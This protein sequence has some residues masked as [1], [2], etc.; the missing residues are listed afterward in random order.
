MIACCTRCNDSELAEKTFSAWEAMR[1][2]RGM[3]GGLLVFEALIAHHVRRK[4]LDRVSELMD[5]MRE[6]HLAPSAYGATSLAINFLQF[7]E[8]D[9]AIEL[10]RSP[11]NASW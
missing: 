2:A 6:A 7:G 9:K 10:F 3:E 5:R 1:S 4:N 8:F 11:G